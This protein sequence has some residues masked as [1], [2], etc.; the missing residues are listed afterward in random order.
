[1]AIRRF[2]VGF[3]SAAIWFIGV[4]LLLSF[5]TWSDPT[6]SW[7]SIRIIVAVCVALGVLDA[8]KAPKEGK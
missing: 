6:P 1:M 2:A 3:C 7:M 4:W 5:V 8:V